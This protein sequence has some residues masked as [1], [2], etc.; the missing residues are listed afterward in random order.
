MKNPILYF[1]YE[2]IM[3]ITK[4]CIIGPRYSGQSTIAKL[5]AKQYNLQIINIENII[6][7]IDRN[8]MSRESLDRLNK[9]TIIEDKLFEKVEKITVV[10]LNIYLLIL[11]KLITIIFIIKLLYLF[12]KKIRKV[13]T[14]GLEV[15]SEMM[16]E[17]IKHELK[18]TEENNVH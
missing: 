1:Q 12:K 9:D 6:Q 3:P 7:S 4:I 16:V 15:T 8:M 14:Q 2:P 5:L 17:V 11:I 18:K 10:I 13:C